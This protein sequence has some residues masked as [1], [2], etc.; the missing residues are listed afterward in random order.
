[1]CPLAFNFNVGQ[2]FAAFSTTQA[3]DFSSDLAV[4][5]SVLRVEAPRTVNAGAFFATTRSFAA[6]EANVMAFG[7]WAGFIC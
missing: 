5:L 2:I 4:S 3:F 6:K 1:M 7:T